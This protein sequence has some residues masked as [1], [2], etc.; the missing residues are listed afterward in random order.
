[1]LPAVP[2]PGEAKQ[3]AFQ[4]QRVGVNLN[5]IVKAMHVHQTPPPPELI[6]LLTDI[7][8]YVRHAQQLPKG[9]GL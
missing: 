3:L 8:H 5:Q 2:P 6:E 1:M 9:Y 4:I 7:R